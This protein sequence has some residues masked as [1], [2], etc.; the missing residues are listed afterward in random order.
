MVPLTS[1]MHVR[2]ELSRPGRVLLDVGTGYFV[3]VSAE[4]GADYCRRKIEY[5][6][7][8]L[9]E[10]GAV[11]GSRRQAVAQINGLLARKGGGAGGGGGGGG[12]VERGGVKA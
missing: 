12:G 5:V 10:I 1:S 11:M 8:K 2:G 9:D 6:K 4:R 7:T 3:D